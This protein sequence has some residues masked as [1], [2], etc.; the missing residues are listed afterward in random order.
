MFVISDLFALPLPLVGCIFLLQPSGLRSQDFGLQYLWELFTLGVVHFGSCSLWELCTAGWIH[1]GAFG[2]WPVRDE[3]TLG[4]CCS[5]RSRSQAFGLR[6]SACRR[7]PSSYT[8]N[9]SWLHE[10]QGRLKIHVVPYHI[11]FHS[12]YCVCNFWFIT[13]DTLVRPHLSISLFQFFMV[14]LFLLFLFSHIFFDLI[15]T[16]LIETWYVGVRSHQSWTYYLLL[17]LL[18]MNLYQ[19]WTIC[20]MLLN[21]LIYVIVPKALWFDSIWFDLVVIYGRYIYVNNFN[22]FWFDPILPTPHMK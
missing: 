6:P 1:V 3:Y 7:W 12:I 8:I 16:T 15:F 22:R 17:L 2:R 4:M 18:W 13:S 21:H 14:F 9:Y 20:Y 5:L 10:S 11:L 19:I